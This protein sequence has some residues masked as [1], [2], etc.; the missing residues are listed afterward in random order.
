[1]YNKT[2]INGY[3]ISV[4]SGVSKGNITKEEYNRI[5][6]AIN[7]KPTPPDELTGYRLREDLTWEAYELPPIEEESE[8]EDATESDYLTAL[9]ELGVE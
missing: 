7:N 2:V 3:I 4:V 8:G 6:E 9:A 1:M 5:M